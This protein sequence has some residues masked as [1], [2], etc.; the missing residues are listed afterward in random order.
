[1]I[2]FSQSKNEDMIVF[3]SW[4]NGNMEINPE[5]QTMIGNFLMGQIIMITF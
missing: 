5:A 3:I 1:M 4:I 2:N